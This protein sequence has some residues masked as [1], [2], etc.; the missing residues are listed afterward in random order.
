MNTPDNAERFW[1]LTQQRADEL[2][3]ELQEIAQE[4]GVSIRTL[5]EW[6]KGNRV[7]GSND[8][9]IHRAFRWEPDSRKAILGGQAP[10]VTDVAHPEHAPPSG[11]LPDPL[12]KLEE[13]RQHTI[14]EMV[15]KL[16]PEDRAP[17]LRRLAERVAAGELPPAAPEEEPGPPQHPRRTG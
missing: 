16:P 14:L 5:Y 7:R 17:A 2:G 1:D 13:W 8:R 6:R 11:S 9:A 15:A 10:L 4:A 12:D 3:K